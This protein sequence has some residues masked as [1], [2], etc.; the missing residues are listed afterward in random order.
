[1]NAL[2]AIGVQR[3]YR[4]HR[5]VGPC[6]LSVDAGERVAL[7]GPN[8]AGKTT[9]LR[10]LATADSPGRGRVAWYGSRS[11]REARRRIGFAPDDVIDTGALTGRQSAHFWCSQWLRG[12][13][14][15]RNVNAALYAF[16]LDSVADEPIATYSFGMR[17]RLLLVQALAHDPDIALLDEPTAGLDPEGRD[18][19]AAAMRE[20]GERGRTTIVATNDCV[21]A[22]EAASR[23]VFLLGG[24]IIRDASPRQ[25]L[26][27]TH[28]Q[29]CAEL[30]IIGEPDLRALGSVRGVGSVA[31]HNGTVSVELRDRAS[32][33]PLV[34]AADQPSG[35][36]RGFTVREPDLADSFRILTGV[37]LLEPVR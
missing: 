30:E 26:D 19:I 31:R 2:E 18:A 27:D 7:M 14:V 5:G 29:R 13:S 35:R 34:A 28:V 21:L 9:L 37:D 10:M 12:T 16:A 32:L 23:V 3:R 33:A 17:R 4:N 20:R 1:M 15:R 8:G 24:R 22:G 36:L 6:D 11:A 25:L